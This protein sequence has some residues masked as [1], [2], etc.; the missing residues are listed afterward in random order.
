MF[1][2]LAWAL[3]V[4][5]R[6]KVAAVVLGLLAGLGGAYA[7]G[8]RGLFVPGPSSDGHHLMVGACDRCH[9]AFRDVSNDRCMGCHQEDRAEDTHPPA[10][11]D[12]P[13]WAAA[14]AELD[15]RSC[16]ACHSEHRRAAAGFTGRADFCFA[17]HDDVPARRASHAAF[18]P[19]SCGRGGCHNYHDNSALNVAAL[20]AHRDEPDLLPVP[21]TLE[22]PAPQPR[23]ASEALPPG[24][25]APPA[26]VGLWRASAHSDAGVGCAD[27]HAPGARAEASC[28]RCHGFEDETFRG[29]KH[30]VR[31]AVGLP[32][33]TPADSRLPMKA[34][35]H[36]T[37]W[38]GTCHD[39]HS[40]D[41]RRAAV[42]AC[43][44][45]H[46]DGHSRA[47]AASPHARTLARSRGEERPAAASVTCATCHLP[48]L[49]REQDGGRRVA[50]HHRNTLTLQP[51]DR[52]LG[53]VCLDCHGQAFA[54]SAL[55]DERLVANNFNG[56][57]AHV[58]ETARLAQAIPGGRSAGRAEP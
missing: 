18:R 56:R 36:G 2:P 50:V 21:R 5:L 12:D 33:L 47:Y 41:T 9:A 1:R 3:G 23:L 46:D 24:L 40:G 39:P 27:C 52:M 44:G 22:R 51:R 14:M 35:A 30:G 29:G 11:F 37:L 28:A 15:A 25:A 58:H 6:V 32:D 48:R 49:E 16:T 54:L 19:D 26:V 34:G 45:C 53:L 42:D 31:R 55:F 43:L 38:C 57:P 8:H 13:R 7:T 4:R 10:T 20:A 17:C